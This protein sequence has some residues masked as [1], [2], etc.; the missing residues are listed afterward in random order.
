MPVNGLG[1]ELQ[2][3]AALHEAGAGDGEEAC[4][5]HL[6]LGAL[7]AETDFAPD[8]RVAQRTFGTV[9]G[10]FDA[11]MFEEGKQAVAMLK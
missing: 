11:G 10:R 6:S 5:G 3:V 4:G 9:V 8:D 2:R 1:E 7:V